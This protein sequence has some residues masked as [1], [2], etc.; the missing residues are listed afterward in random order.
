MKKWAESI[1]N[2]NG[3][4]ATEFYN[5]PSLLTH[6]SGGPYFAPFLFDYDVLN[7]YSSIKEKYTI[8]STKIIYLY[9]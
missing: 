5:T 6:Y 8:F 4:S 7:K 2:F 1:S 3:N 9:I